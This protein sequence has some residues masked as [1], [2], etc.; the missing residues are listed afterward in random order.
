VLYNHSRSAPPWLIVI[1]GFLGAFIHLLFSRLAVDVETDSFSLMGWV[2][3]SFE[4]RLP[5]LFEDGV[6]NPVHGFR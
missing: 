1:A 6:W 3:S 4:T 5:R 2:C